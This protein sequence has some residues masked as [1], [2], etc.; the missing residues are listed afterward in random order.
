MLYTREWILENYDNANA[1][2]FGN[3]LPSSNELE[4]TIT[5]DKNPWGR[6][7]CKKFLRGSDGEFHA[8]IPVLKLSN[9]YDVSEKEKLEVLIHEM[10]HIY[11]YFIEPKYYIECLIRRRW[12]TAH[13]RHGHGKVFYEQ[14]ER[15]KAYGFN[16][17]RFVDNDT[18]LNAELSDETK[19]KLAKRIENGSAVFLLHLRYPK[20]LKGQRYQWCYAS[21]NTSKFDEWIKWIHESTWGEAEFD[22]VEYYKTRH[23]AFI[24]KKSTKVGLSYYM[25]ISKDDFINKYELK[26]QDVVR[27]EDRKYEKEQLIKQAQQEQPIQQPTQ[28]KNENLIPIFRFKTVQGN[29]IEFRNITKDELRQKLQERLPK[30]S[31][32]NIERIMNKQEYYPM[33]ESNLKDLIKETILKEI[34]NLRG[35]KRSKIERKYNVQLPDELNGNVDF[36]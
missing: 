14:A 1:Q 36:N 8:H 22:W 24:T 33:N 25:S 28:T 18:V 27:G 30:W 32:E 23:N 20:M 6:G 10:C 9:Y 26:Y 11:E 7:G 29:V 21:C 15:L 2:Y 4:L 31:P 5:M 17:Q 34:D 12:T 35:I 16:V 19:R 3:L 13:P